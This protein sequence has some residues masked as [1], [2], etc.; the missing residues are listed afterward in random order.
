MAARIVIELPDPTPE[1]FRTLKSTRVQSGVE[2]HRVHHGDYSSCQFNATDRGNA[3]LSPIRNQGGAIIPTIY[4]AQS[5][6]CAVCEI[7]LRAP[8]ALPVPGA[9]T[10]VAPR[11]FERH[12]HSILR[13]CR[14]LDFVDLTAFGQRAVSLAGN[15]LLSGGTLHYPA[16]R[17]WAEAIHAHAPWADGIYY[18]SYQCGPEFA[19]MLF[20]DRCPGVIEQVGAS[21]PIRA[22]SVEDEIRAIG[23][24]I[25]IEYVDL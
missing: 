3:R 4:A 16:T 2:I 11:D 15:A 9:M 13:T 21:R 12:Q 22:A 5:F 14:E 10:V 23:E 8:D 1:N 24:A 17:R 6:R 7:I 25:G 18:T 20:G 19:M